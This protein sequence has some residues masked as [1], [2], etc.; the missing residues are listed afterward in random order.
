MIEY[1]LGLAG[2]PAT[3]SS[4]SSIDGETMGIRIFF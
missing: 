1:I 4:I 3:E 2:V